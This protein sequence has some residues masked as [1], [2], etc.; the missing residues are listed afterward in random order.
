MVIGAEKLVLECSILFCNG[1]IVMVRY[2]VFVLVHYCQK[3]D[4]LLC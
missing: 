4:E 1:Q 3:L 2:V